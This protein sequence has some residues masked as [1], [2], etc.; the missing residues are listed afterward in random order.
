MATLAASC[1]SAYDPEALPVRDAQ[2]LIADF[3][4]PIQ[5]VEKVA[6]RSALDR[7]L[8]E[9][10]V[11]PICVPAHDNSAMDGYALRGADLSP[12]APT[13]LRVIGTVY[14][15]RPMAADVGAGECM[16]I[17]TGGV[18]PQELAA[19]IGA[20]SVTIAPRVLRAGDNRRLRGED[21]HTG[22]PA[23]AKGRI[24]RP[25]D[26]GLLASLGI[27]EVAVRRRLRVAFFSTGD[28][29]RSVGDALD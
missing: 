18:M 14:A 6:L 10:I 19:A 13:T 1:L 8:A 7:V 17:M 3:I 28:E 5:A 27:A 21:L 25:A 12:D 16:R 20:D 29:L 4:T 23:L 11:S 24:V 15:G 26:L 2:R 9:D 22:S